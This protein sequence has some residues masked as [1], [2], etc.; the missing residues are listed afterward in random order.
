MFYKLIDDVLMSGP[1]VQFPTGFF[2]SKETMSEIEMP[3]EGW[4]YFETE[5]EA[6]DFFGITE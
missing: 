5:Q 1:F 3:H 4:H 2:L 6:K